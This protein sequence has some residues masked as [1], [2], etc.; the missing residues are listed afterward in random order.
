[1]LARNLAPHDRY[2]AFVQSWMK[3]NQRRFSVNVDAKDDSATLYIY[4]VIGSSVWGDG[5]T[6]KQVEAELKEAGDVRKLNVYINSP[7]GLVDDGLAIFSAL[8][9]HPARVTTHVTGMAASAASFIVQAGDER[10]ADEP[11]TVMIHNAMGLTIGDHRDHI[12]TAEVLD[13]LTGQIAG[14]YASRSGRPASTFRAAMDKETYFAATEAKR[15]GL[16]DAV[17][18]AK[19]TSNRAPDVAAVL[20]QIEIDA[21][22]AEIAAD[23]A[24]CQKADAIRNRLSEIAGA[25]PKFR[26]AVHE[27]GHAVAALEFNLPFRGA[28]C[29]P[30]GDLLGRLFVSHDDFNQLHPENAATLIL[31]GPVAE[32]VAMRSGTYSLGSTDRASYD[33]ALSRSPFA[34]REEIENAAERRAVA[35][36]RNRWPAIDRA[37]RQLVQ[38]GT[39]DRAQLIHALG[40]N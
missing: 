1:M 5:T 23:K 25:N 36:V 35:L 37:A 28:T 2:A 33:R 21:R 15:A 39:M 16:L 29:V 7:G 32:A 19:G 18:P 22:L 24:S 6:A 38:A 31:A 3:A 8:S 13:K 30:A 9:R 14:I 20:K 40:G 26:V 34:Y 27:L 11:A 4:D 12:A 17:I 10:I